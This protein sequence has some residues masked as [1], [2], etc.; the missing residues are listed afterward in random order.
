MDYSLPVSS[1]HK[2]LQARI[3]EWVSIS[4]SRESSCPWNWIQAL[5]GEFFTTESPEKPGIT[6]EINNNG[7]IDPHTYA[8]C[9]NKLHPVQINP[10]VAVNIYVQVAWK[11]GVIIL[12]LCVLKLSSHL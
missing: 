1:I 8:P 3:L 5:A 7:L 4:S 10:L 9:E 2:I 12:S 11:M 6:V